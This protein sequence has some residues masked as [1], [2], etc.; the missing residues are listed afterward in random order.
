MDLLTPVREAITSSTKDAG[1]DNL[2]A[3][4]LVARGLRN[5]AD[6][7][8]RRLRIR[9]PA[10]AVQA[11]LPA[12][13]TLLCGLSGC[14]ARLQEVHVS[15]SERD[16]RLSVTHNLISTCVS[17]SIFPVLPGAVWADMLPVSI[18]AVSLSPHRSGCSVC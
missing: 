9:V 18:R 4:R 10:D 16:M 7:D 6:Q 8:A 5:A 1:L 11:D 13:A 15:D 12:V 3:L 14:F 17:G 2:A